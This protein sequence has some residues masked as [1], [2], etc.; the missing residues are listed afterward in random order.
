MYARLDIRLSTALSNTHFLFVNW[1]FRL[2]LKKASSID[3]LQL[4]LRVFA[5]LAVVFSW[6]NIICLC[7]DFIYG[8]TALWMQ[9]MYEW[10]GDGDEGH[11]ICIYKR[12]TYAYVY[13]C[14]H[15]NSWMKSPWHV[16]PS[17]SFAHSLSLALAVPIVKHTQSHSTQEVEP[18]CRHFE[19][20]FVVVAVVYAAFAGCW[21]VVNKFVKSCRPDLFTTAHEK[22]IFILSA[23]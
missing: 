23:A 13:V 17:H 6:N 16:A 14:V 5:S 2:K 8:N 19:E 18:H 15:M 9:A 21:L 3:Q 11:C 10:C 20:V 1:K 7:R 4:F 12:Y 22:Q